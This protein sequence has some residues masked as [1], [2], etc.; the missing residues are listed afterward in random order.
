[1]WKNIW[2][3]HKKIKN[4]LFLQKSTQWEY[5]KRKYLVNTAFICLLLN[6]EKSRWQKEKMKK[7]QGLEKEKS[8]VLHAAI[9]KQ[10]LKQDCK[11]YS[12]YI[13]R[14]GQ[15]Q[16]RQSQDFCRVFLFLLDHFLFRPFVFVLP[17]WGLKKVLRG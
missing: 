14:R 15:H 16:Q 8:W 1:M 5:M 3:S 10:V 4:T 13:L 6:R 2:L 11:E 12:S 7:I 17:L 9:K